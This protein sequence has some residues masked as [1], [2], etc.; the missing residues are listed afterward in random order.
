MTSQIAW[1]FCEVQCTLI[2]NDFK[3][4]DRLTVNIQGMKRVTLMEWCEA[5]MRW[6]YII[7]T[8][9]LII[10]ILVIIISSQSFQSPSSHQNN[11]H[12]PPNSGKQKRVGESS[13]KKRCQGSINRP[14]IVCVYNSLNRSMPDEW[15]L[16]VCEILSKN[17]SH[18]GNIMMMMMMMFAIKPCLHC[19]LYSERPHLIAM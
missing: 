7:L 16:A 6:I 17:L 9:I 12:H 4:D 1:F 2:Q 3:N 11:H 10:I 13:G 19:F 14:Q 8:I 18:D 15:S 5:V